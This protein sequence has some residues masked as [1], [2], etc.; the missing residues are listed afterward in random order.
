MDKAALIILQLHMLGDGCTF[1]V[2]Y[3]M[4]NS[5]YAAAAAYEVKYSCWTS[6]IP[7]SPSKSH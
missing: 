6:L 1:F 5:K 7:L 4:L 2:M 3:N